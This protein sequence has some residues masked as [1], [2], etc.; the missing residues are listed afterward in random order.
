MKK[1]VGIA[2]LTNGQRLD[3]LKVC[4]E[5]FLSN[6]YYRPLVIGV[7]DNGSTDT[8]REWM[9]A[10]K[11]PY[12]VEWRIDG[13]TSDRGCARG[14]NQSIELVTDCEF[15]L[16][17]ESD[18]EH[19]PEKYSGEDKMWLHRAIDFMQSGE[20]DYLY[21]RRMVNEHDI[22]QHWWSQWMNRIS[23]VTGKYMKCDEFWWS[24]NPTLFRMKA[25]YDSKTLPLN[26]SVDGQ[27][28]TA[29]WSKPE[30]ETPK[31][32]NAWIHKW[33]LFVHELPTQ[34]N[35]FERLG[36]T[37]CSGDIGASKCKYGFFV[38]GDSQFCA[39]CNRELDFRD[40]EA[41]ARRL[42]GK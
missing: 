1:P 13:Y 5:S 23:T 28:G 33:G 24:N 42:V 34:G 3:Y 11:P 38:S 32:P 39:H 25:L 41:H 18:F 10:Y 40:M 37:R 36:M 6:C 9:E 12:G 17:L 29:G 19:L 26:A 15:V 35:V 20:C 14:T 22:F 16:H 2:I 8:T 31:P 4:I 30:L 7:C 27:K 21:L